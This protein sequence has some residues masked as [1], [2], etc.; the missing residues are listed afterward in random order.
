MEEPLTRVVDSMGEQ[1]ER[2]SIRMNA[3]QQEQFILREK[4]CGRK[5]IEKDRRLVKN[6]KRLKAMMDD[7][8]DESINLTS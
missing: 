1:N 8:L 6:E 5:Q 3:V 4:A 7:Y 2:A